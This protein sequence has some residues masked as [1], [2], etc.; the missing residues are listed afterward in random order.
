VDDSLI[1][2]E[3]GPTIRISLRWGGGENG[4]GRRVCNLHK[5]S[6]AASNTKEVSKR[7]G[8]QVSR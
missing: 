1:S 2:Q 7:R 5:M 6:T 8:A 3:K 4:E